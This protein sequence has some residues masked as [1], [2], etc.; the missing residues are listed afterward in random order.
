MSRYCSCN[1]GKID[2]IFDLSKDIEI[3]ASPKR[4]IESQNGIEKNPISIARFN[5]ELKFQIV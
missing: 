3:F 5:I 4:K 1:L 2:P